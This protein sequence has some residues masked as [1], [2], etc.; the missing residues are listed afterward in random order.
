MSSFN[1]KHFT[2]ISATIS[3]FACTYV[4]YELN[5]QKEEFYIFVIE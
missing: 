3:M 4:K 2:K 5:F 1:I